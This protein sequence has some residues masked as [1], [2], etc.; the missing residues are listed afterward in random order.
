M[1]AGCPSRPRPPRSLPTPPP[2]ASA[3]PVTMAIMATI[4]KGGTPTVPALQGS[5]DYATTYTQTTP[6]RAAVVLFVTDG[7]P[8]GCNSTT[9]AATMIAATASAAPPATKPYRR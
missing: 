4:P 6:G 9:A 7:Q 5:I 1:V 8:N 3:A 2:P